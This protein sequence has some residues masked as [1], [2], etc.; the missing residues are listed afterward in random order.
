MRRNA[1]TVAMVAVFVRF[2]AA[3][4]LAARRMS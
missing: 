4:P 1:Y 3:G 2:L